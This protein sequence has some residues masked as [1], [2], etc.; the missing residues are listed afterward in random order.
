M[1]FENMAG[2]FNNNEEHQK[3]YYM[4]DGSKI[5]IMNNGSAELEEGCDFDKEKFI[6][7]IRVNRC[8]YGMSIRPP[9]K[10]TQN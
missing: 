3:I 4:V 9:T 7:A 8:I 2:N 6:E 5:G 10:S 1:N